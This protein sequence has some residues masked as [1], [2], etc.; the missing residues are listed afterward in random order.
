MKK[1]YSLLIM[2]CISIA[3]ISIVASFYMPY[4]R[5]ETHQQPLIVQNN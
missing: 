2:G 1:R 5:E 3:I 4:N